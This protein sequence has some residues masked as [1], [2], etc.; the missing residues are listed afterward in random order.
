MLAEDLEPGDLVA[1]CQL[2]SKF[3]TMQVIV[4]RDKTVVMPTCVAESVM[5]DCD[6]FAWMCGREEWSTKLRTSHLLKILKS[7][8]RETCSRTNLCTSSSA[9]IFRSKFLHFLQ[10]SVRRRLFFLLKNDLSGEPN[11]SIQQS[12]WRNCVYIVIRRSR[13]LL[14][15]MSRHN[16]W[17]RNRVRWCL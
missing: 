9:S 13:A 7:L 15:D 12:S 11:D 14:L 10:T 5:T 2:S 3:I 1:Y 6:E 8:C 17:R 4:N 16:E